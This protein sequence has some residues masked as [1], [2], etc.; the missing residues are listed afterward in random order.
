MAGGSHV[1]GCGTLTVTSV[2][3]L[4]VYH[5]LLL[6]GVATMYPTHISSPSIPMVLC[7]GSIRKE[8]RSGQEEP[9]GQCFY[10]AVASLV[11]KHGHSA[12][13]P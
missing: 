3:L 12:R 2:F 13:N 11:S 1:P 10:R 9:T 5:R 6:T 8:D 7:G 4:E